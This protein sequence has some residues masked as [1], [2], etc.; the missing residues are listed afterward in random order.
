M[1]KS[2]TSGLVKKKILLLNLACFLI[3]FGV[4]TAIR[5]V[6]MQAPLGRGHEWVTGHVLLTH[7]VYEQGGLSRYHF[8]PAWTY[9]KPAENHVM[10]EQ[11]FR[12]RNNTSYYVS[13][14]PFAF[15]APY[16]CFKLLGITPSVT[17]I[18]VFSVFLHLVCAFLILNIM[19]AFFSKRLSE[20]FFAPGLLAV[21]VYLFAAGNLWF[22]SNI[23]FADTLEQVF[24][25]G[26]VFLLVKSL[27]HEGRK[28]SVTHL[29]LLG[30]VNFLGVY[31]EWLQVFLAFTA[32]LAAC[33]LAFRRRKFIAIGTVLA[34][35]TLFSLSLTLW[36][37]TSIAGFGPLKTIQL[38][39][40]NQRSGRGT[41]SENTAHIG[42]KESTLFLTKNYER[43][44]S[45]ILNLTYFS[46][47]TLL[48]VLVLNKDRRRILRSTLHISLPL[49]LLL[50]GLCMHLVVFFNFNVIHDFGT[51]KFST[52]F[53]LAVGIGMAALQRHILSFNRVARIACNA[54]F[55]GIS[56]Y[57]ISESINRYYFN[58]NSNQ[59]TNYH[60][61][62]GEAVRKYA[63]P[64]EIV[65][66]RGVT[67]VTNY[68]AQRNVFNAADVS[69]ARRFLQGAHYDKGIFIDGGDLE[70]GLINR[71]VRFTVTGDSVILDSNYIPQEYTDPVTGK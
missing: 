42:N 15:L 13:Y 32:F 43:H 28:F 8:A 67:P 63:R 69:D 50:A 40:Y 3:L 27:R 51:L 12:D 57:F 55:L 38:S 46:L 34:V 37:Y 23:Y 60:L 24:A 21:A 62:V 2:A 68:F 44:Y 31:T 1:N 53:A 61:N 54:I 11:E 16:F 70:T 36:Q 19:Y 49:L 33:M 25:I 10:A 14:P 47:L 41:N 48:G 6:N 56:A 30:L 64:D 18:R 65:F 66:G 52:F 9:D 58:N 29:L 39:K 45:H 4:A 20:D 71:I 7:S 35:S 22:H 59:L 26:T 17:A 5:V